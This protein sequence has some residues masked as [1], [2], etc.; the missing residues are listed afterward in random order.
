MTELQDNISELEDTRSAGEGD[1]VDRVLGQWARVRPDLDTTPV[2]VVAR[3]GRAAAYVSAGIDACLEEFGLS[4]AGW[5]VLASLRRTGPPHRLSPT[6]LYVALMRS[7]GA[8][9]H[10]LH[11]LERH[12]LIT[13]VPDPDDARGMLVELSR[14]GKELVDRIA[15]LHL[16]NERALLAPL[17]KEEQQTLAQLLRKLLLAYEHQQPTPPPSGT[18]GRRKR[19]SRR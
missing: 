2:A 7:S 19:R 11:H 5:D 3:L 10:R 15:R 13:R 6:E 8:M 12:G 1:H 18:G 9:T 17:S 16:D 14:K 4:R